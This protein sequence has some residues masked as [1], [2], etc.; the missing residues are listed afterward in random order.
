MIV[1]EVVYTLGS[2]K[3]PFTISVILIYFYTFILYIY[4]DY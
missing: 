1:C 2:Y 3:V 4:M